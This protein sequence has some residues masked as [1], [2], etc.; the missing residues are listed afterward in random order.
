MASTKRKS[1]QSLNQVGEEFGGRSSIHGLNIFDILNTMMA[2]Y[3][4]EASL[5]ATVLERTLLPV[6]RRIMTGMKMRTNLKERLKVLS[7]QQC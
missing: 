4:A 5:A 7:P 6:L 3:N 2:P 1:L